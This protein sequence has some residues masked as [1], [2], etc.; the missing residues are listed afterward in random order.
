[1]PDFADYSMA[2]RTYRFMKEEPLYPFGFGL[3]YAKFSFSNLKLIWKDDEK[4]AVRVTVKNESDFSAKEKVQLY[5][6]FNDLRTVTPSFQLCAVAPVE[7]EGGESKNVEI[8]ADAYWLK[9]VLDDGSRVEPNGLVT[10]FVGNH[11]PDSRSN[12]L[13]GDECVKIGL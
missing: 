9:A 13:C 5:A 11:Q 1:L 3:S 7:L 12:F 2:G 10:L 8:C 4:V 6:K